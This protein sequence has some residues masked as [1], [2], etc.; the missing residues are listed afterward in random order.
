M[1]HEALSENYFIKKLYDKVPELH[2]VFIHDIHFEHEGEYLFVR[3]N[4]PRYADNPPKKWMG[5]NYNYIIVE[6]G[7]F[8]IESIDI[9]MISK[10]YFNGNIDI[11]L[12]EDNFVHLNIEGSIRIHIKAKAGNIQKVT[13]YSCSYEED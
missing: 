7:F 8:Y 9:K 2:N 11:S 5:G 12:D 13:A 6:V 3:F 4:L 10:G 1:W